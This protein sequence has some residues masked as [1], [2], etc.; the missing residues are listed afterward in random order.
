MSS[1]ELL[2]FYTG[3]DLKVKSKMKEPSSKETIAEPTDHGRKFVNDVSKVDAALRRRDVSVKNCEQRIP[4]LMDL[5]LDRNN[6]YNKCHSTKE[7]TP[8]GFTDI[9]NQTVNEINDLNS[10]GT[11]DA[12]DF[13]S[14]MTSLKD[15]VT[16]V[17]K[18]SLHGVK[19]YIFTKLFFQDFVA[20]VAP[21]SKKSHFK[22]YKTYL[23]LSPGVRYV[24]KADK[25]AALLVEYVEVREKHS[26]TWKLN[27]LQLLKHLKSI[28]NDYSGG[29]KILLYTKE[30]KM[31]YASELRPIY[32]RLG[33]SSMKE[34][35]KCKPKV[36][37]IEE[38]EFLLLI[39]KYPE[40]EVNMEID[41]HQSTSNNVQSCSL[42]PVAVPDSPSIPS[43]EQPLDVSMNGEVNG[44]D[45]LE[46]KGRIVVY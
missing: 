18:D 6:L 44:I 11:L 23:G 32:E 17:L 45:S 13:T 42:V 31:Q 34:F 33:Y 36:T 4:S 27:P 29:V 20:S 5:V 8:R 12:N 9:P 26:S 41:D 40:Q 24:E 38:D 2:L 28:S 21:I 3:T 35:F 25:S 19:A 30:G 43:S 10:D 16:A 7:S 39:H 15:F 46:I 37:Y 1:R 22:S 14:L